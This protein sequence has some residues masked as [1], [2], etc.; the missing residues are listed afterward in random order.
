[1]ID[2]A[3]FAAGMHRLCLAFNREPSEDLVV[4]YHEALGEQLSPARWEAAVH[5]VLTHER[6]FPSPAVLLD[7]APDAPAWESLPPARRPPEQVAAVRAAAREGLELVRAAVAR[8][9][10]KAAPKEPV[11]PM[12]DT[13]VR[14]SKARMD[15][16]ER[17]RRE[18]TK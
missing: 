13:T 8:S 18:I 6:F 7:W 5:A 3:T 12:K 9:V 1:M 14:A 17:Q 10:P 4:V 2:R 16:L 15:E 11:R